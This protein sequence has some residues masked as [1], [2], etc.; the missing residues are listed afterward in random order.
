MS[1]VSEERKQQR[2]DKEPKLQHIEFRWSVKEY[3][4]VSK[5]RNGMKM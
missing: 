3:D 2:K 5:L 1:S 4:E